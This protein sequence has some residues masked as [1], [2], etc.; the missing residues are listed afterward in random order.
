[1][2]LV[3]CRYVFRIRHDVGPKVRIVGNGSQRVPEVELQDSCA[4][5]ISLS[6]VQLF[7]RLV[8]FLDLLCNQLDIVTAFLNGHLKDETY[9]EVPAGFRDP[10]RSNLV[11]QIL[12]AL[13]G[14]RQGFR[15][16]YAKTHEFLT[17]VLNF[18]NASTYY[19]SVLFARNA[20]FF[21]LCPTP[22][23]S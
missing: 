9:A 18:K 15:R 21:A 11:R 23:I 22:L 5:V 13:Y 20:S 19:S 7:L 16:W 17:K 2:H 4:P 6:A 12:K 14:L 1:M 3:S 8:N 10:S